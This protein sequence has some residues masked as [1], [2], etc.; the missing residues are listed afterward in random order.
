[1]A[2]AIGIDLGTT[3]SATAAVRPGGVPEVLWNRE[4]DRL[5]P[6]VVLF[7]ESGRV[8][9]G[10]NAKHATKNAPEDCVESVKRW[11]GD[12]GWVFA[13]SH[14][15][16]HGAE[17]ITGLILRRLAEDAAETLGEP[18]GDVVITVP[19]HFDDARRKATQDAGEIAGLN[20]LRLISEPA[21]VGIAFAAAGAGPETLMVYDLGGGRFDVTVLRVDGDDLT[22]VATAGDRDLGGSDF[23][24]LLMTYVAA[25]V[26]ARRGPDLLD[27]GRHQA[28]L[29]ERCEQAKYAL[30]RTDQ[31]RLFFSDAGR[32]YTVEVTR[33]RFEQMAEDLLGR[34][35]VITEQ[36]LEEAGLSW[37]DVDRILLVGG[38]TRMPMVRRRIERQSGKVPDMTVNPDEA[39]AVG[40]AI[41]ATAEMTRMAGLRG[42]TPVTSPPRTVR[43]V[44]PA[45]KGSIAGR[46][47]P[48]GG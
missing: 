47:P 30:S 3:Y 2:Q 41:L 10:K 24:T 44:T 20:V 16:V 45:R 19:A 40:A 25:E 17:E 7:Q 35:S 23:D 9:V 38:S 34:T 18:V 14:G 26:S 5:T 28:G 1:M 27:E 12:P 8:L 6:S 11:M 31:T 46:R 36:V 22:V 15:G 29:R 32:S 39:V 48:G 33:E 13:D 4:G 43:D 42:D 21:A 37:A